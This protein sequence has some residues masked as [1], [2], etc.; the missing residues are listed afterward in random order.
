MTFVDIV[1]G[2][3]SNDRRTLR[4]DPTGGHDI[5]LDHYT[6]AAS[7]TSATQNNATIDADLPYLARG[8]WNVAILPDF[9]TPTGYSAIRVEQ[10][11]AVGETNGRTVVWTP[12]AT[13]LD[14]LRLGHDGSTSIMSGGIFRLRLSARERKVAG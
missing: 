9:A 5:I 7:N 3:N 14:V 1:N 8:R 10:S 2:T 4:Y 12:S 11:P 6:G 13:V